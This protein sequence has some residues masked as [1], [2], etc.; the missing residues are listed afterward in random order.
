MARTAPI[1]KEGGGANPSGNNPGKILSDNFA[2]V[3]PGGSVEVGIIG[4]LGFSMKFTA[5]TVLVCTGHP[6]PTC[7]PTSITP[8][9]AIALYLPATT[10]P[11]V[12]DADLTDPTDSSSGVFGG[13]VLA[14]QLNVDF[15]TA[16][17]TVGT[18]GNLGILHICNFAEGDSLLGTPLTATQATALNFQSINAVLAEANTVLGGGTGSF[19]LTIPELNE[20]VDYLNNAFDGCTTNN[21]SHLCQ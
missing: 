12:L 7:V 10:S 11:D 20:L 17:V 14:L 16:G 3:Y 15:N 8:A 4:S 9:Q 18:G 6:V 21:V 13:Q 5:D 2:T 19:G 1:P